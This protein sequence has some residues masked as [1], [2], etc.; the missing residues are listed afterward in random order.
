MYSDYRDRGLEIL[1][2]PCNQ[3]GSQEPEKPEWI[4]NF[5]EKFGVQFHMMEVIQVFG[6]RQH[7]VYKWLRQESELKGADMSWNFE[8]FLVD[9]DGRIVKYYRTASEPDAIRPDIEKLLE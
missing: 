4:L 8:K 5:V 9:S 3:F 6:K 7:P 2:F 1:A